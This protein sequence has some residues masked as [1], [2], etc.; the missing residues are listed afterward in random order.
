MWFTY[1]DQGEVIKDMLARNEDCAWFSDALM[2]QVDTAR[3][4][5]TVCI[6]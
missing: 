1:S 4:D 3:F 6:H 2:I 5:H